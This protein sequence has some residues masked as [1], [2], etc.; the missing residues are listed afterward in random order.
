[1]NEI[2]YQGTVTGRFSDTNGPKE[3][4]KG[5]TCSWCGKFHL[6]DPYVY[7][8]WRD[9]LVYTC[10]ACGARH[11]CVCGLAFH[12]KNGKKSMKGKGAVPPTKEVGNA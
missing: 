8:H 12:K 9:V 4:P 10:D 7:A 11:K 6:F 5:F 1:M 2:K 3:L